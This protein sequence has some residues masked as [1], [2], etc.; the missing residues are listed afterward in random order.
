MSSL[1]LAALLATAEAP[2]ADAAAPGPKVEGKMADRLRRRGRA[3]QQ[4]LGTKMATVSDNTLSYESDGKKNT[5]EAHVRPPPDRQG[6]G[7][8][9]R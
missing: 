5:L 3:A 9:W 1:L 6:Q 4:R 7:G 8:R 2:A